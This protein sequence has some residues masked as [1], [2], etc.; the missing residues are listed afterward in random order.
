MTAKTTILHATSFNDFASLFRF[1][2]SDTMRPYLSRGQVESI[3][4]ISDAKLPAD[5][6][7]EQRTIK[8]TT[9]VYIDDE[10]LATVN[11]AGT[12]KYPKPR[13]IRDLSDSGKHLENNH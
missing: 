5:V 8:G 3:A 12:V 6:T 13:F 11:Q 1:L 4:D 2:R 10:F 9:Y 7:L